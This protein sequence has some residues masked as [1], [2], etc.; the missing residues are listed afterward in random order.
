MLDDVWAV[1][2]LL[3]TVAGM[4]GYST[5]DWGSTEMPWMEMESECNWRNEAM[6]QLSD[7]ALGFIPALS[8]TCVPGLILRLG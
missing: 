4:S 6:K 1:C 8:S 3:R 2:V 7:T 5:R